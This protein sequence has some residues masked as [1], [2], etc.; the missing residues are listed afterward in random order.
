MGKKFVFIL[1]PP[2][3][4]MGRVSFWRGS[5][6]VSWCSLL[7]YWRR[8]EQEQPCLLPIAD[9]AFAHTEVNRWRPRQPASLLRCKGWPRS[10][11]PWR[12]GIIL[13]VCARRGGGK[14][15]HFSNLCDGAPC[16]ASPTS[17][18]ATS[19]FPPPAFLQPQLLHQ[20]LHRA[21]I[22]NNP[23]VRGLSACYDTR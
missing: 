8:R 6:V 3:S 9:D 12:T 15:R 7:D 16:R 5:C 18:A 22:S 10:R 11:L 1:N 13:R 14:H 2:I 17:G 21:L 19:P 23:P 4:R 20:L